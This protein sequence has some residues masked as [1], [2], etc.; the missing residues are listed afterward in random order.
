M[1]GQVK[2]GRLHALRRSASSFWSIVLSVPLPLTNAGKAEATENTI[3]SDS[4]DVDEFEPAPWL[5]RAEATPAQECLQRARAHLA[6]GYRLTCLAAPKYSDEGRIELIEAQD[7]L[8]ELAELLAGASN[9]G[10]A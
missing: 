2:L 5:P 7:R 1:D 9:Q 3:V 4:P 8:A 6:A 10:A